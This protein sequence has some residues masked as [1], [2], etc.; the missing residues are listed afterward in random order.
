MIRKVKVRFQERVK[1]RLSGED[2]DE[3]VAYKIIGRDGRVIWATL[4]IRLNNDGEG[5]TLVVAHDITERKVAEEK[6]Q[7][8]YS[9]TSSI[10]DSINGSFIALD[11]NWQFTYINQRAAIPDI[12]S[13]RS[14]REIN[15]GS[16]SGNCRNPS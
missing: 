13:R 15:L 5:G 4:N 6:L 11:K 3:S 2:I 16:I 8:A 12:L 1:K 7:S 14:D 10:L 9:L